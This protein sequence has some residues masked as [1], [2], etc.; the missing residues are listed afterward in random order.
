MTIEKLI[1]QLCNAD[2]RHKMAGK[3][4]IHQ[5]NNWYKKINL[6]LASKRLQ[7]AQAKH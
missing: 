6:S 5:V 4:Y 2:N 1:E 3:I 7:V